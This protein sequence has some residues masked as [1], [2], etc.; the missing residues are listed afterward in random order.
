ME[1]KQNTIHIIIWFR[2]EEESSPNH[3]SKGT[4]LL[5]E[6]AKNKIVD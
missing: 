6:L 2:V 1:E 5:T 3:A 4:L